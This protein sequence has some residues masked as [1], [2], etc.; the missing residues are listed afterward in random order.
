MP[1]IG[2]KISLI[3]KADIRYEGELF[4]VDPQE[5]TIALSSVRSF[6]TEDREASCPVPAQ[7]QTYDFILFRG[8]DIKDIRVMQGQPMPPNDPAIV[9]HQISHPPPSAAPG[10]PGVV[11]PAHSFPHHLAAAPGSHLMGNL[12]ATSH[13]HSAVPGAGGYNPMS[14]MTFT[15]EPHKP[16]APQPSHVGGPIG[17]GVVGHVGHD[18]A[19]GPSS[20]S[21]PPPQTHN[22]GSN[23]HQQQQTTSSD[24]IGSLSRSSTPAPRKSPPLNQGLHH[25]NIVVR[26]SRMGMSMGMGRAVQRPPSRQS[27]SRERLNS[28]QHSSQSHPNQQP[29]LTYRDRN[30]F[31]DRNEM[32]HEFRDYRDNRNRDNY[33][34]NYRLSH[35]QHQRGSG[36]GG[37][38]WNNHH[39]NQRQRSISGGRRPRPRSRGPGFGNRP[40]YQGK[41]KNTLKFDGD[42]DFDKANT[43]FN[44]MLSKL[45]DTKID[46]GVAPVL[47]GDVDGKKDDSGNET[48]VG[49]N[50]HDED[51]AKFYDKTKSFFD[52]ISCEAVERS[53][54]GF[55][56][57]DWRQER[58][59][60]SETFGVAAT[61][62]GGGYRGRGGF[63]YQRGYNNRSYN[64]N[65]NNSNQQ[66]QQPLQQQ[67]R[68]NY[69][70][71]SRNNGGSQSSSQQ[72]SQPQ[73][74]AGATQQPQTN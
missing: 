3:S 73:P 69:H 16:T 31:Y 60:N 26:D 72:Q 8:T 21:L 51:Q 4:T 2:S 50:D 49:E 41:A 67:R 54:G 71:S 55:Q 11:Q 36:G 38:G 24:L 10:Y 6:G 18:L 34:D 74:A 13:H 32:R 14:G 57:P 61:R 9:Q 35:N 70:P 33:R 5:C 46:D 30:D 23:H 29:A 37:G 66:Q 45:N 44:E 65:R 7:N 52:N 22:S 12:A 64:N 56:R 20:S 68:N 43:E 58:K 59:V 62:R 47:N 15:R 48:G 27:R 63:Y 17:G 39:N 19:G 40:G 25:N 1:E 28:H 42:Y 53:K